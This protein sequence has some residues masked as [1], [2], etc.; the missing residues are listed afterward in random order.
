MQHASDS[1]V[2]RNAAVFQRLIETCDC[3]LVHVLMRSVTAVKL[4][5]RG[6]IT[7]LLGVCRRATECFRPVSGKALGVQGW[8]P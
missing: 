1:L 5:D 8:Y 2:V 7:I 3:P 4:H 6:L